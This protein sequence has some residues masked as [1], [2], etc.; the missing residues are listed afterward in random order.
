MS[1]PNIRDEPAK[2]EDS[3]SKR[4]GRGQMESPAKHNREVF[5]QSP[6]KNIAISIHGPD[7]IQSGSGVVNE[8]KNLGP[9]RSA[10]HD[11]Q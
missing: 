4:Q 1:T 8:T 10:I 9:K 6:K 5:S 2:H 3:P 7:D 11:D